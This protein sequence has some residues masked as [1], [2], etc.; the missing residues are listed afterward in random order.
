MHHSVLHFNFELEGNSDASFLFGFVRQGKEHLVFLLFNISMY[1]FEFCMVWVRRLSGV[2]RGTIR[3]KD[4]GYCRSRLKLQ[5][6]YCMTGLTARS[7]L[8]PSQL[9]LKAQTVVYGSTG[10]E[11]LNLS[12]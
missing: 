12:S 6:M 1:H 7:P 4:C 11:S 3:C 10:L 8:F 5:R 9:L 2:S